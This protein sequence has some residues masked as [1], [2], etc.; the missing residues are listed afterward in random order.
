[1]VALLNGAK[2]VAND[3]AAAEPVNAAARADDIA[4]KKLLAWSNGLPGA[5][6]ASSANKRPSVPAVVAALTVF[7]CAV[8]ITGAARMSS[9]VSDTPSTLYTCSFA[10]EIDAMIAAVLRPSTLGEAGSIPAA[11]ATMCVSGFTP[12]AA[13]STTVLAGMTE[14]RVSDALNGSL[15]PA[16]S[17]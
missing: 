14:S 2:I 6:F 16:F 5:A 15:V 13:P 7:V 9:V 8:T 3:P 4:V 1:V 17:L 10:E 11:A 12:N